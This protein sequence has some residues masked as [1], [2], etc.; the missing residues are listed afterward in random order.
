MAGQIGPYKDKDM[1]SESQRPHEKLNTG[2]FTC[3]YISG[4][5]E[6]EGSLGLAGYP[7]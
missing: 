1:G 5:A 6:A 7:V 3:N 2:A 4:A